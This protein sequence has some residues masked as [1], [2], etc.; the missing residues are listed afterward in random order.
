MALAV[1]KQKIEDSYEKCSKK[2]S[3]NTSLIFVVAH[4]FALD[5]VGPT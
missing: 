4:D 3:R 5:Y 1:E 2:H